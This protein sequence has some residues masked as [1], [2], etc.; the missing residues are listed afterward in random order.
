MR[1]PRS[2]LATTAIG[3]VTITGGFALGALSATSAPSGA[4]VATAAGAPTADTTADTTMVALTAATDSST[5]ARAGKLRGWWNGLSD[6]QQT[7]LKNAKLTRPVGPLTLEQRR[8]L[9]SE[10]EAAAKTCNVDLPKPGPVA[11][12]WGGL[13]QD[14]ITCIQDSGVSRPVGRLTSAE[15]KDLV[16]QVRA[17]AQKC[18]VTLPKASAGT[19][20][21]AT[22]SSLG[23]L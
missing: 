19:S 21:S 9:R 17:A 10:V 22:P 5:P 8:Q 1:F 15:R 14:Q 4:A 12:F 20:G 3:A 18:G 23:S 6:T 16:S 2:A 7:C 11:A 13:T